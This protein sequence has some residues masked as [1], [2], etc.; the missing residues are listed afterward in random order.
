VVDADAAADVAARPMGIQGEYT[1]SSDT[2]LQ[3]PL[4]EV[5]SNKSKENGD[6]EF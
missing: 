3:T 6:F 4:N 1:E 5:N 2:G